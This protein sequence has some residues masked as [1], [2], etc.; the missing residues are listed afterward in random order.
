MCGK[1]VKEA[2]PDGGEVVLLIGRLEQGEFEAGF[3]EGCVSQSSCRER[4]GKG[5]DQSAFDPSSG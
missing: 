1:L 3:V 4:T 5:G 2:I